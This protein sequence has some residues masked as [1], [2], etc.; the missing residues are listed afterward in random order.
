[1][2]GLAGTLRD[3]I[4]DVYIYGLWKSDLHRSL[5]WR[6]GNGL[7]WK[8]P[9]GGYRAPIRSWASRDGP[10]TWDKTTFK[11]GWSSL[12][13]DFDIS[14][15]QKCA[16]CD[17]I[18]GVQ[19]AFVALVALLKDVLLAFDELNDNGSDLGDWETHPDQWDEYEELGTFYL[20]DHG[21]M[22]LFPPDT[23]MRLIAERAENFFSGHPYPA[24]RRF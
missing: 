5:V 6:S 24:I 4:D 10:V 15:P 21:D 11:R 19:L 2:E 20:D 12:I 22:P 23:Q 9:R 8:L 17:H 18:R 1:M 16:H 7:D 14:P 3:L 13:E